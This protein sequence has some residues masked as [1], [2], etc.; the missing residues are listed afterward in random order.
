MQDKTGVLWVPFANKD[1]IRPLKVSSNILFLIFGV[2]KWVLSAEEKSCIK[3]SQKKLWRMFD[4]LNLYMKLGSY[5]RKTPRPQF[6]DFQIIFF[7]Q[8]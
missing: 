5:R 7:F 2:N 6:I 4:L 1:G 8:D 3:V